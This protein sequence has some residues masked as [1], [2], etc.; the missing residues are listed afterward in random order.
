MTDRTRMTPG[1]REW[2]KHLLT[3]GA[4]VRPRH[5]AA[6][7]AQCIRKGWSKSFWRDTETK[8]EMT[9]EEVIVRKFQGVE[10]AQR[11]TDAGREALLFL[12]S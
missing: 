2:L 9:A 6:P 3:T 1:E 11:I 7:M 5:G 10:S 12:S 8:M 4:A